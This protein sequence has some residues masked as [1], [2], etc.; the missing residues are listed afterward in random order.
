[1]KKDLTE[2]V[3]ILDRSGSMAMLEED[4]IG[5]FNS[6]I[7]KQ[8]KANG[9]A[10]VSTLLFDDRTEVLHDRVDINKIPKMTDEQYYV[11]GC[12]ALLD[13]IGN[14][15]KHIKTVHKY[16]RKEDRPEKTIFVITTDGLENASEHYTYETIRHMIYKQQKKGWEF[17]FIG[18]NIDSYNEAGRLGIKKNR[19]ANY[20]H[21]SMGT[22]AVYRGV[23][24]AVCA[25]MDCE[26][27]EDVDERLNRSHWNDAINEDF[28]RRGHKR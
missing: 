28:N 5:G 18:A 13:A 3:Y 22:K 20:V 2:I 15:I 4:T 23:S 25:V 9:N 8:K 17:M 14:A 11:R 16:A 12:T 10:L 24:E 1:M 7:E 6:M 27:A 21:D 19:T 26:F